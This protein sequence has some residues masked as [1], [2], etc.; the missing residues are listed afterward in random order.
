M[1]CSFCVLCEKCQNR[2]RILRHISRLI[3]RWQANLARIIKSY[4]PL[5]GPMRAIFFGSSR[6]HHNT[7]TLSQP[8]VS[9]ETMAERI[10]KCQTCHFVFTDHEEQIAHHKGDFHRF[11]LK[12]KMINLQ[13]VSLEQFN[14][15]VAGIY[16]FLFGVI[17]ENNK[18]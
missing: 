3:T 16:F 4:I 7:S 9:T 5:I 14:A 11:N 1:G 6:S 2:F 13:P 8:L 12:R 15:K 18:Q 10:F 17:L